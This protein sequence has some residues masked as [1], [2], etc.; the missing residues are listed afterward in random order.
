MTLKAKLAAVIATA[1]TLG[2][3][4]PTRA[5]HRPP[6]LIIILADD[7]GYADVG[8]NGCKDIP[9]PNIDS[10]AAHGIRFSSG[11]VTFPVCS[12]SRAG[13]MTGRY[14]QRFGHERNPRFEPKNPVS[15]LPL[16]ETTLAQTLGRAGY[17]SGCI[18]K[19]HLGAYPTLRPLQRGFNEFFGFLGGG[20][21]YFPENFTIRNPD[22]AHNE[23]QSY[24]L[25][26]MR[27]DEPVKVT[28]YLTDAFSDEAVRF[29]QHHR[30][31]RFFLYLA[32]NAPHTPMQA[33]A[34]YLARFATIENPKRRTYA[35]MV[36]AMDDGVG[37][38]LATLGALGLDQDTLVFFLSDN[39]GP[40]K[41]NASDNRPLRGQKSDPW[42]GGFRV[43]FA[44]QWPGHL[45]QGTVYDRPVLSTD[46]YATIAAL[47]GA[48][49]DPRHPLDGTNLMPY[50]DGQ[51]PGSPHPTI[52]LRKYDQ[53]AFAVRTGDYK[54]VIPRRGMPPQ[55]FDL[56][57]DI[58]ESTN[59]AAAHPRTLQTL[60]QERAAWAAQLVP[61]VFDGLLT[62][63]HPAPHRP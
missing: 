40:T 46:I 20:H 17:V 41:A 3:A 33:T 50:L 36:S 45:P 32:Y 15:G 24:R 13:L 58:S 42:E 31:Q 38:L 61:P 52:Y 28:S 56:A 12:P 30:D 60:E 6:N 16:T 39:G 35:A 62:P 49:L 37:R 7:L 18:G 29:V 48:P 10:I 14:P 44:V 8:F 23:A 25:W 5:A 63:R 51:N 59:I 57:K 26:I 54:L 27:G 47:A 53:G 9:T 34:K 1:L 4:L 43:P 55:L 19:W 21:Q 22:D 11:Y 2:L